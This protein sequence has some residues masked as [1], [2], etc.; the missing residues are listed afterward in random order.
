MKTTLKEDLQTIWKDLKTDIPKFLF[1]F[2]AYYWW[3]FALLI[4]L[5]LAV[6]F[7]AGWYIGPLL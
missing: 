1:I 3:G 7:V 4:L 5:F 2:V 6:A